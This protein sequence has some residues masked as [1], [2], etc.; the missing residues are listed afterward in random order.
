M[1]SSFIAGFPGLALLDLERPETTDFDV[2]LAGQGLFDRFEKAVND[3]G[4]VLLGESGRLSDL[5]D[6]VGFGHGLSPV[7]A[8]S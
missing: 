3:D 8:P 7:L 1:T 2:L 6:E 5:L 4:S